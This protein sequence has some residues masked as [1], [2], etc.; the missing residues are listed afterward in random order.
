MSPLDPAT[1]STLHALDPD[2]SRGL[3]GRLVDAF[4]RTLARQLA[5]LD[6]AWDTGP[7]LPRLGRAAHTLKSAC[8]HLAALDAAAQCQAVERMCRDAHAADL[9]EAL[10]QVRQSLRDAQA[11]LHALPGLRAPVSP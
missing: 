5:E 7:D 8:A 11:A 3:L 1:L 10:T 9:P 4:D 6:A 2:G